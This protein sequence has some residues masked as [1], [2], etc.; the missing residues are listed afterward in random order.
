MGILQD[1]EYA[2]YNVNQQR[3]CYLVEFTVRG[4]SPPVERVIPVPAV[5]ETE[6]NDTMSH[7]TGGCSVICVSDIT[8]TLDVLS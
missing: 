3:I 1:D 8:L 6:C 7:H 2:V 4:D 5:T